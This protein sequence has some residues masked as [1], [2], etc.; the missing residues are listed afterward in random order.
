MA[1]LPTTIVIG[2]T[3]H[4]AFHN[5]ANTQVNTNTTAISALNALVP[6]QPL[7]LSGVQTVTGAKDFTGGLTVNT[8]AVVLTDDARLSDTRTP[9]D[10]TVTN[11]S[12]SATAAIAQSKLAL[13]ITNAEVSASAAIAKSKL[14]ALNIVNADISASAAI[15]KS[16]LASL[17]IVNADVAAGA[18]IAKSKLAALAIADADVAAG[19]A[20]A[21]SKLAALNIVDA[22]VQAGAGIQK[23]KLAALAIT[24]ADVSSISEYK[25]A[26]LNRGNE[27]VTGEATLDRM[28]WMTDGKQLNNGTLYLS[29]FTALKTETI[30]KVIAYCGA[31]AGVGATLIRIGIYSVN[32]GTQA[33]TLVASCPSTTSLFNATYSKFTATLSAAFSKVAGTRYAVGVLV[34]GTSTNPKL[35]GNWMPLSSMPGEAPRVAAALGSQTDLPA[36]ITDA[37]LSSTQDF[38]GYVLIP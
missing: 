38:P 1:V 18:A 2:Q 34:L 11:A 31:T 37:S 26:S 23:S 3:G 21:K 35:C 29:Y 4:A 20:I 28:S 5:D 6:S 30:T 27:L 19:A 32:S 36:S 7:L 8:K 14:A 13:S 9:T 10:G 33:L 24:D 15:A 12:V 22:D 17:G 16:K 25:I